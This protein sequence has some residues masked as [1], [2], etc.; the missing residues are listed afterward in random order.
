MFRFMR[1]TSKIKKPILCVLCDNEID[2]EVREAVL[3]IKATGGS[4]PCKEDGASH[5]SA[6]RQER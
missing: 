2:Y 5:V 1:C 3:I 4:Q 6:V